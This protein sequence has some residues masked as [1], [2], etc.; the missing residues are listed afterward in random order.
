VKVL[1]LFLLSTVLLAD[2]CRAKEP[3]QPPTVDDL[4]N[5]F[6]SRD[7]KRFS[8]LVLN[9]PIAMVDSAGKVTPVSKIDF[10]LRLKKCEL[11]RV[12]KAGVNYQPSD[13]MDWICRSQPIAGKPCDVVLYG[14]DLKQVATKTTPA[15]FGFA[16]S[17]L[18][19]TEERDTKRCPSNGLPRL[20]APSGG[21]N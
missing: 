20:P 11:N 21:S 4:A 19:L 18:Y 2:A 12:F 1:G 17:P 9:D 10:I 15:R 5:A 8:A 6:K 3:I 7:M 16:I 14:A 13:G